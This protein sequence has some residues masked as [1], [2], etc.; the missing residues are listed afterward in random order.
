MSIH[1]KL[2]CCKRQ[3]YYSAPLLKGPRMRGFKII[4]D[5][6]SRNKMGILIVNVIG[7]KGASIYDV[8]S[9]WGD[10]PPPTHP[11]SSQKE[12]NQ[13]IC[14]SD[15]GGGGQIILT[16]CGRYIWNFIM[17]AP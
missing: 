4:P 1:C 7:C 13:L 8:C 2:C 11:K 3:I 17:E 9:G 5:I 10:I 16:F 15:K 14:D 12:Q 6:R